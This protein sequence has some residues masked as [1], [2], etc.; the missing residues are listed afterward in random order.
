MLQRVCRE[1]FSVA[2]EF[3]LKLI[4]DDAIVDLK[5]IFKFELKASFLDIFIKVKI[6]YLTKILP[7]TL[8]MFLSNSKL[9]D[10]IL[11][12]AK[13]ISAENQKI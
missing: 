8:R 11:L 4:L 9:L 5:I 7:N 12:H 6:P 1:I 3:W 13:Q 2:G 10:L